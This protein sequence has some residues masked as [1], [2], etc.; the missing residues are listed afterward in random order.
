MAKGAMIMTRKTVCNIGG[1]TCM[2]LGFAGM[3]LPLLPTTIFW[4]VAAWLFARSHP[5]MQKKIYSWPKVGPVVEDYLERG[6][7]SRTT[8]KAS[9][10]GIV[11]VG[12]LSLY[13]SALS[14]AWAVG[15][16]ALL[17]SICYYLGSR[18]E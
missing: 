6:V 9:I 2:G 17:L 3:L 11:L 13:L 18:P 14:V 1:F 5:E 15:I 12:G 7:V 16:T 8:K 10:S 4:I